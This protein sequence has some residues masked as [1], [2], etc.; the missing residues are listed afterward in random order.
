MSGLIVDGSGF[1]LVLG[2]ERVGPRR[3]IEDAD[4]DLLKRIADRYVRANSA[5]VLLE[6]GRELFG[7]LDGEQ[8]Q[9]HAWLERAVAPAVL[10]VRG[11]QWPSNA[12]WQ[13]L[14]APFELLAWPG[15]RFLAEDG[16]LRFGVVRRLGTASAPA[17][18]DGYRLGVA[19]M[20][21]SPTGQHEL[22]FEAEEMAI[23][24][25]VGDAP[26]HRLAGRGHRRPGAAR[27]A[28]V[29]RQ[30]AGRPLVLSRIQQ[31]ARQGR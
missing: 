16:I 25:A 22:D 8:R 31:L 27:R 2:D 11:P 6:L 19:F 1:E 12:V 4:V 7:W 20:A 3:A 21:S 29:R 9:L 17:E 24:D 23:L 18:L 14:R 26:P 5:D 30:A 10:E 13:L 28:A 15:G